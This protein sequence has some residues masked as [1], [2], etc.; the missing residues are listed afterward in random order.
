MEYK[1]W[2]DQHPAFVKSV[3]LHLKNV[4]VVIDR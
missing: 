1:I 4:A 3:P 2:A